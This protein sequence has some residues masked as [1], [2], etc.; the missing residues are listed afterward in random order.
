MASEIHS[1][2]RDIN[3]IVVDD[4]KDVSDVFIELLQINEIN[5]V[6]NG[7]N[8]KDAVELYQ[9]LHPDIIFMDAMMPQYDGFYGLEKIMEYDPNARVIM[10]TGSANVEDKLVA[11]LPQQFLKNQ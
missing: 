8:G 4:D 2:Y 7:V 9:K 11:V 5:V 3:A 10:V 1:E 6:G